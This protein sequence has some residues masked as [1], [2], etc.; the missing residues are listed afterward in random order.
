MRVAL[1]PR[2]ESD[3]TV[4]LGARVTF[5]AGPLL[6]SFRTRTGALLRLDGETCGAFD[7]RH[8]TIALPPGAGERDVEL[9]IERRSLPTDSLPAGDGWRWRLYL[10]RASQRPAALRERRR[11][12]GSRRR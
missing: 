1:A 5:P 11:A 10:A 12:H 3:A 4:T 9:E 7:A 2:G 8:E 6:L